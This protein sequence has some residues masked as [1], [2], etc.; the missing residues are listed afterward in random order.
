MNCENIYLQL[1][2]AANVSV[3]LETE[4]TEGANQKVTFA[5]LCY[6]YS[7][8]QTCRAAGMSAQL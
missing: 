2:A 8:T 1:Y 5:G 4:V 3:L 7:D 6:F